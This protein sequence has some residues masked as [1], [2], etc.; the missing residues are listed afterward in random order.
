MVEAGRRDTVAYFEFA[1]GDDDDP[2]D[3]E[4]WR[5]CMPALGRTITVEAVAAAWETARRSP[6]GVEGFK[7]EYLSVWTADVVQAVPATLWREA[8]IGGE[9]PRPARIALAAEV[10]VDRTVSTIALAGDLGDGATLLEIVDRRPG[11]AWVLDRL[12]ELARRYRPHAIALDAGGPAAALVPDQSPLAAEVD[13][14]G[15]R[16][17]LAA[18]GAWHDDLV[19][20]RLRVA[21]SDDLDEAIGH[22]RRRTVAGAW[23][24]DR[25]AAPHDASA[26]VA[27]VL[28][29]FALRGLLGRRGGLG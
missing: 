2:G 1:A 23:L 27:V 24:Y 26:A 4:V 29:R 17:V 15:V 18:A 5:A 16:D 10:D 12:D 13:R 14:L 9:L 19:A 3:P 22:V 11:T 21:P 25:R 20:G 7:R 8:R 6:A 28:A